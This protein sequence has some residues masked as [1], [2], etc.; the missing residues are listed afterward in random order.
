MNINTVLCFHTDGSIDEERSVQAFKDNMEVF[1]AERLLEEESIGNAVHAVFDRYAG[2]SLNMPALISFTL[3]GLGAQP[4]NYMTL[5]KKIHA[6]IQQNADQPEKKDRK[7]GALLQ[8]GEPPRT[9]TFR[10]KRGRG[11]SSGVSRWSDVPT[12]E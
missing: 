2:A 8:A 7:T 5:E 4:A 10:I 12:S 1:K 9:R 11:D 6:Y 3:Q